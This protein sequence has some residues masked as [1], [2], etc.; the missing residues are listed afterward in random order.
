MGQHK[1]VP[2]PMEATMVTGD[3]A[4][5]QGMSRVFMLC[6]EREMR[7]GIFNVREYSGGVQGEEDAHNYGPLCKIYN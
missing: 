3:F 7:E 2:A 1:P 4:G 5:Y 6:S